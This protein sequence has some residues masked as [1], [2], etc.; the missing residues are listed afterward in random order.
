MLDLE[1]LHF[2]VTESAAD[3]GGFD[4]CT[5]LF[6]TDIVQIAFEYDFLMHALLSLAAYHLSHIRPQKLSMYRYASDRHAAIGLSLSHPYILNLDSTNCHA[7]FAFSLLTFSHA[8]ASQDRSKPSTLFFT[9]SQADG[10]ADTLQIKWVKLHRGTHSILGSILPVLQSGPLNIVLAPWKNLD[11]NRLNILQDEDRKRLDELSSA[12]DGSRMSEAQKVVLSTS[13][14]TIRRVFSMMTYCD[15]VDKTSCVMA[16]FSRVS[17]EFLEML[18]EK[19]PEA[20]LVIA[21]L[22]VAMKRLGFLR[23]WWQDGM[24]ENLLGTILNELGEGWERW[25]DWPVEQVFRRKG[26]QDNAGNIVAP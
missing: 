16:W 5:T 20:L 4:A 7:C 9:P 8:W 19:V 24:A 11:P 18:E 1:L 13:V 12:W 17:D 6:Q 15:E 21:Y 3:F 23:K 25:T 14:D 10:D 26:I 22:S 2:W